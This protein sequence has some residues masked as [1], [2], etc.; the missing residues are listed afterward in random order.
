MNTC[1]RFLRYVGINT[2]SSEN[3][4]CSPTSTCQF[5]LAKMLAD[6]LEDLGVSNVF[7]DEH[8]YV[9]GRISASL[10]CESCKKVGFI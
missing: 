1:E 9:Y 2:A 6:E 4:P 7:L 10:G 5:D 3:S 8:C